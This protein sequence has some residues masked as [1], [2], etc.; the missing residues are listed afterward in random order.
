MVL[1]ENTFIEFNLPRGVADLSPADYD[2]YRALYPTPQSRTGPVSS[3][4]R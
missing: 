2:V 4:R 3:L 1:R